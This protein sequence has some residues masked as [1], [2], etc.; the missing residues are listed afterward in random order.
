MEAAKSILLSQTPARFS[1]QDTGGILLG[2][3][4]WPQVDKC[5]LK[6][7]SCEFF[8]EWRSRG[9]VKPTP[10][11]ASI[12]GFYRQSL[13]TPFQPINFPRKSANYQV[14]NALGQGQTALNLVSFPGVTGQKNSVGSY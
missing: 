7:I 11:G 5:G 1:G 14:A 3:R 2:N 10:A 13:L 8:G 4:P 9:S 6:W 12:D